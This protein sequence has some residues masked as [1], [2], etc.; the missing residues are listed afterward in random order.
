M[1]VPAVCDACG[2]IFPS[3][4]DAENSTNIGFFGCTAGPCPVCN[5]TG[6]VP[7]GIYNFVGNTIE[8]LSG[9]ARSISE[10]RRLAAILEQA[11]NRNVSHQEFADEIDKEI[12]ELR[13]LKD[14]LPKTRIE[15]YTALILLTA[16]VA[17]VLKSRDSDESTSQIDIEQV[18][19]HI[20]QQHS[21]DT[22][23]NRGAAEKVGRNE[24]CP[25]K[26]GKKFKHCHGKLK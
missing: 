13:S 4:F 15:L 26:S 17:L 10:L 19:N 9:P 14:V 8:L 20:Y 23:P 18:I 25:C 11:Q 6:H 5:G 12:P 21:P 16:I 7:D 24:P 3:G 1:R 22:T 2:Y